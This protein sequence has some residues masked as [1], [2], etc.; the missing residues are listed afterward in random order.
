MKRTK[1]QPLAFGNRIARNF[2][3]AREWQEL[4]IRTNSWLSEYEAIGPRKDFCKKVARVEM[5]GLSATAISHTEIRTKV[6]SHA[7]LQVFIPY[8]GAPIN[9][10][11]ND[12]P[13]MLESGE[14]FLFAPDGDRTGIG[15][16]RS[17]VILDIDPH[18]LRDTAGAMLGGDSASIIDCDFGIPR[19]VAARRGHFSFHNALSHLFGY[20][21][22]VCDMERALENANLADSIYRVL[23]M[24]L[25]PDD[26]CDP[27][28]A[29]KPANAGVLSLVTGYVLRNI[30]AD[31][32]LTS[33][34]Q[35]SG[36]SRRSLQNIF[37]GTFGIG[38]TD[39]IRKSKYEAIRKRLLNAVAPES[40]K[41]IA[42]EYNIPLSHFPARYR[43]MFGELPSDTISR[44]PS[45]GAAPRAE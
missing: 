1:L 30:K 40:V 13:V 34:E 23:A 45:R 33:L 7:G 39:W 31:I 27:S 32:T 29:E 43:E 11:V 18:R 41:S 19:V 37:R 8:S 14:G 20:L 44:S 42:L 36:Y 2:F 35:L 17:V 21:D 25:W 5:A 38:P 26:L 3:S 24:S 4:A 12:V 6:L 28:R 15:G 10:V 16:T 9:S 22:D